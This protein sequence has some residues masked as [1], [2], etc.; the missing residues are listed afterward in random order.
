[1]RKRT[2]Q[3][4]NFE[5]KFYEGLLKNRPDFI[6]ALSLLGNVY[7]KRGMF[8]KGL[9]VDLRL[10]ELKPYDP[11]VYYNLACSYSLLGK[12][13]E[14]LRALKR[15][16]LLGYEDLAYALKDKDLKMLRDY[17]PFKDFLYKVERNMLS[18]TSSSVKCSGGNK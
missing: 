14:S 2:K 16:V 11:I 1:M 9:E 8:E 3:K 6:E 4:R 13:E 17:K 7:T 10:S 5:I 12:L 15:A 18:K